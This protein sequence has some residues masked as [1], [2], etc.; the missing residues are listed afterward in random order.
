MIKLDAAVLNQGDSAPPPM[1]GDL[2]THL[3]LSYWV[4][5]T[6]TSRVETKDAAIV[7]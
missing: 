4:S 5:T 1:F 3:R 6:G 7:L 2:W